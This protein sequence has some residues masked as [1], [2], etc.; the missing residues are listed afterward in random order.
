[1]L[2]SVNTGR[3]KN[4]QEAPYAWISYG[5]LLFALPLPDTHDPNT[6]DPAATWNYALDVQGE[7]FATEASVERRAMP[8]TWDWPLQSP[9]KLIVNAVRCDWTPRPRARCRPSLLRTSRR[10]NALR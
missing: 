8:T 9:V 10:A 6:P 5:P 4:A 2:A 3:D 1:M 7:Q